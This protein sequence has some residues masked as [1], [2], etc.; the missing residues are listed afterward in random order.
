[1]YQP[2]GPHPLLDRPPRRP[3]QRPAP[4]RRGPPEQCSRPRGISPPLRDRPDHPRAGRRIWRFW[5]CH[6]PASNS[7]RR[8]RSHL[9]SNL[10]RRRTAMAAKNIPALIVSDIANV[11][12][13]TGFSGSFGY[14]I[15]APDSALFITDS[16]YTLQAGEQVKDMPTA[17]F[18]SP[19]T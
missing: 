2:R 8:E 15:V 12:W 11:N 13:L 17:W 1:R 6:G 18:Q 16:R 3:R 4:G 7:E 5:L 14:A 19:V 9:M 10:A